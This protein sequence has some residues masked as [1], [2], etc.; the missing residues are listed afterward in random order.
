MRF[1]V[2]WRSGTEEVVEPRDN[3]GGRRDLNFGRPTGGHGISPPQR[4][5]LFGVHVAVWGNEMPSL[6]MLPSEIG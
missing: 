6:T 5:E 1:I 3:G 2:K 4:F